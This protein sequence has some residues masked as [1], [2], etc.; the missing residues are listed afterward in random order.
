MSGSDAVS[1]AMGGERSDSAIPDAVTSAMEALAPSVASRFG[2]GNFAVVAGG[3]SL[4]RAVRS[5]RK[6][7]RK[8]ALLRAVVGLFWV[9]V[10][11]AQRRGRSGSNLGESDGSDPGLSEV[12]RGSSD[13]TDAVEPGERDTDHATGEEVVNTT[14]ADVEESDT[15]PELDGDPADAD[16]DQRDVTGTDAVETTSETDESSEAQADDE[17]AATDETG[18]EAES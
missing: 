10:A 5:Y 8:R 18:D 3:V 7:K 13:V 9:G 14:D 11:V 1:E 16:V 4:F 15:A 2:S 17:P 6:G 12:A